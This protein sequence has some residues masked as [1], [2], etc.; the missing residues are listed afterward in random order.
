MP[1]WDFPLVSQC[2]KLNPIEL[3]PLSL[4]VAIFKQSW[5]HNQAFGSPGLAPAVSQR[6]AVVSNDQNSLQPAKE[7]VS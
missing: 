6:P 4:L 7:G 3:I 2:Q 5:N 1:L